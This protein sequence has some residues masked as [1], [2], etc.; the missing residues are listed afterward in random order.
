MEA[1]V[2]YHIIKGSIIFYSR[3]Y[4]LLTCDKMV[5]NVL[6][7]EKWDTPNKQN[8]VTVVAIVVYWVQMG[9]PSSAD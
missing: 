3:W 8:M 5:I 6:L 2:A 7:I 4:D 1:V 9:E